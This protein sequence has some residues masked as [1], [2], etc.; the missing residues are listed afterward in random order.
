MTFSYNVTIGIPLY[1]EISRM[2]G[3]WIT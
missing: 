1:I 3:N 2:V